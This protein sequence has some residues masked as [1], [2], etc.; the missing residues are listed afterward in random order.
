MCRETWPLSKDLHDDDLCGYPGSPSSTSS[1][2]LSPAISSV[3]SI[4]VW[5]TIPSDHGLV[6]A[7]TMF[8]QDATL[9]T[10][11]LFQPQFCDENVLGFYPKGFEYERDWLDML[12]NPSM[13]FSLDSTFRF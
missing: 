3:D 1:R 10:P 9:V 6:P 12:Q 13:Q 8:A 4:D 2:F 5:L 7:N 11:Y